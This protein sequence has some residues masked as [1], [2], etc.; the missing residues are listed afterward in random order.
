MNVPTPPWCWWGPHGR[1]PHS[2][3]T[4]EDIV[5]PWHGPGRP[6]EAKKVSQELKGVPHGG[7]P[8]Q[9]VPWEPHGVPDVLF[10]GFCPSIHKPSAPQAQGGLS[11]RYSPR[12][13]HLVPPVTSHHST[14]KGHRF[15]R[16]EL[17]YLTDATRA[18]H[19]R[20]SRLFFRDNAV[21]GAPS[22]P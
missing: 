3:N 15:C 11:F 18:W 16:F 13:S 6:G 1:S 7:D 9:T 8:L 12:P 14:Q 10:A 20:N 22:I 2:Y 19:G 17:Q 21:I 5:R 4:S